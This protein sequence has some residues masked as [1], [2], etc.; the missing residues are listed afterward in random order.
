MQ[1]C[2]TIRW[3][4]TQVTERNRRANERSPIRVCTQSANI[5]R[6]LASTVIRGVLKRDC[7]SPCT[8]R[9]RPR[10]PSP[11]ITGPQPLAGNPV[12]GLPVLGY[13]LNPVTFGPGLH[14]LQWRPHRAAT[15][16]LAI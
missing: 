4:V 9:Q 1:A 10:A 3:I 8:E 13:D 7:H 2:R 15:H 6:E 14:G 16:V 12:T 5:S 11:Q